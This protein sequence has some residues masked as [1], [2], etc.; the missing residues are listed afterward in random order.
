MTCSSSSSARTLTNPKSTSLTVVRTTFPTL[1]NHAGLKGSISVS[2]SFGTIWGSFASKVRPLARFQSTWPTVAMNYLHPTR[3]GACE[4]PLQTLAEA[5][6]C[7]I[8]VR[9]PLRGPLWANASEQRRPYCTSNYSRA[10]HNTTP[11]HH[12]ETSSFCSSGPGQLVLAGSSADFKPSAI[13]NADRA[14]VLT[15]DTR[16]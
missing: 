10:G 4:R 13:A 1:Y 14:R 5:C 12:S 3:S 11:A 15:P 9:D 8:S 2:A 6:A 16:E 7:A